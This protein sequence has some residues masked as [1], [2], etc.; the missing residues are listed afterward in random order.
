M[1]EEAV[2]GVCTHVLLA[3]CGDKGKQ[4]D[5]LEMDPDV[6]AADD[7]VVDS[8]DS[9]QCRHV[10]RAGEGPRFVFLSAFFSHRWP[11]AV[12]QRTIHGTAK[13]PG[14]SL[15]SALDP[16]PGAAA[17]PPPPKARCGSYPACHWATSALRKW[18]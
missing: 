8:G 1:S 2:A 15:G 18:P 10:A 12:G 11:Q 4:E 9:Q 6:Q 17:V 5:R 14:A 13:E 16:V 7:G 3:V